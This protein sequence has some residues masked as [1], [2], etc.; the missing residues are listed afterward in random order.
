M[1]ATA[2]QNYNGGGRAILFRRGIVHHSVPVPGLTNFE[3]TANQVILEGKSM[4][5]VAANLT[6]SRPLIGADL[7]ACFGGELQVVMAGDLNA[8][9][10]DWNSRLSNRRRKPLR[11]Y[12]DENSC[13]I[14][15][16]DTPATNPYKP[17][18]TQLS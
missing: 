16:P 14:F 18:A 2:R 15:G 6:L 10:V 3:A 5:V 1:S 17:S 8:K 4:I 12:A 13:L 7:T 11:D 9:H